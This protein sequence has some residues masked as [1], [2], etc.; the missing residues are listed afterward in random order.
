M[1]KRRTAA[2]QERMRIISQLA[3]KR[4]EMMISVYA[5]K[6]GIY[7]KQLAE[8]FGSW[9]IEVIGYVLSL[10]NDDDQLRLAS[11]IVL[12][13]GPANLPGLQERVHS[14]LISIR[15]FK[16]F[17]AVS[18]L[19]NCTLSSW[20]GAKAWAHTDDFKKTLITKQDYDELGG[21]F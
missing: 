17:S 15:P 7:T 16:S 13:G 12:T 4:K 18:V 20:Y 21:D 6:I 3:R 2:G 11:N 1:A 9:F 8:M 5:M 19:P 14:D 10:F